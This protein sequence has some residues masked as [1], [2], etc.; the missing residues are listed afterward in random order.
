MA[1]NIIV[2]L[3]LNLLVGYTGQISLGHAA[4]YGVGAY[5]YALLSVNFQIPFWLS[6][7][8]AGFTACIAGCIIGYP[9]LRMRGDY[10]AIVTLGFGEIVRLILNNW[11]SLTNGP[12][13]ILGV[14]APSFLKPIFEGG[15]S[16]EATDLKKLNYLY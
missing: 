8:V 4:F 10:L 5:T 15:M 9:T 6:L 3:G 7:P 14:K 2:A 16:F 12:N 1:I 11:M 13:G